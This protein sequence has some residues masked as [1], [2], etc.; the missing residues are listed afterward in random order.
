MCF[1]NDCE[2]TCE[3][4]ET[5]YG[6]ASVACKCDECGAKIAAG[7]YRVHVHQQ[8]YECCRLCEDGDE[9]HDK[10]NY[11]EAYDYDCC[12]NC[13]KFLKAIADREKREGCPSYAQQPSLGGLYEE[14]GE[15]DDAAAYAYEAVQMFPELVDFEPLT[16][17]LKTDL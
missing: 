1:D 15:R 7:E 5:D 6:D 4:C 3:V 12:E 2:W 14:I 8:E 11:G 16:D 17:F 13:S 10:C 9:D